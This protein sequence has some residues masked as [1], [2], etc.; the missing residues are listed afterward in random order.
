VS[1]SQ[2][3][4]E[5][6][7]LVVIDVQQAFAEMA[8][9][10]AERNNPEAEGNIAAVIAAFRDAGA[11]VIHIRHASREPGSA[12]RP[13]ATGYAVMDVAR[14]RDGEPV[15]VKHVNSAFIGTDLED[16]LRRDGITHVVI[17]G[18][19]TNH[20]VETTS[21]MSGNLGFD[22]KLVADATWTFAL[23]GPS[24]RTYGAAEL[25]DVT[26]ANLSDEFAEIVSQDDVIARLGA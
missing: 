10:G 5:R 23:T 13:D 25:H 9:A 4:P 18:A 12:L 19:T 14:E 17:V 1:D 26:L 21:R 11:P 6:T 3:D 8:A 2:L 24:G 16:R 20:C 7:A 15:L 22:T